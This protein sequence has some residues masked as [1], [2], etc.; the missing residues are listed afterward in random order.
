MGVDVDPP[1]QIDHENGGL[2][3]HSIAVRSDDGRESEVDVEPVLLA[4]IVVVGTVRKP[5]R[6][7]AC[8]FVEHCWGCTA[9]DVSRFFYYG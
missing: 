7:D 1:I 9:L 6:V 4:V 8:Q 2:Q 3:Q 5:G